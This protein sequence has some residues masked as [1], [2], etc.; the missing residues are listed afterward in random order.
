MTLWD[1]RTR[2]AEL[3][4]RCDLILVTGTT[5]VNGTFDEILQLTRA[6]RKRLVVFGI[7]G[8]GVCRLMGLERWCSLAQNGF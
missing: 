4:K 7:T 8:A 1:A 5:L 6:A 3:I 2:T